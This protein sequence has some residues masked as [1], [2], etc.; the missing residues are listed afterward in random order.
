MLTSDIMSKFEMIVHKLNPQAR[1]LK[2]SKLEGGV[3]AQVT[4][5]EMKLPSG[6]H[7][8][9]VVRQ[10]GEANLSSDPNVAAHELELLK[11][12]RLHDLPVPEPLCADESNEILPGPYL[13]VAFIDG[14]T[15]D[16]PSDVTDFVGQMADVLAKIH[17]VYV[18]ENLAFLADQTKV[19]TKKLQGRPLQLDETL[20][21][22]R[23]RDT[24]ADAWP[25]AQTNGSALLH[26]DFWPGNTMWKDGKLAGV[27]DWED[28]GYGDPLADLG[29]GRLEILMFFG[30]EAMEE[31]T[32]RYQSLMP[33][34]DY[35][36]LSYWDLCAAL[37]PAGKM[38]EWGLDDE[39]LRKLQSGHRQFVDQAIEKLA[40]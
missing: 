5:L 16:D 32:R 37:R 21:E 2:A 4:A 11:T 31:F 33:N 39:T 25:P 15:V 1:L 28:A 17:K 22:G 6:K 13:V 18:G 30:V 35:D 12:L 8:K 7:Q 26:G 20:S 10:Y 36:N 19:F 27:I 9:V 3:S 29:N 23:I 38:A 14:E 40:A 24:L 34:L